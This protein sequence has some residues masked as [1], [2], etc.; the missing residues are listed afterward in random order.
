MSPTAKI[1]AAEAS[2][3]AALAALMCEL[4]YATSTSDM[5]MRLERIGRDPQYRTFVA[6]EEGKVCGMI[7]SFALH[8]Y[9][10]NDL[11]GRIMAL[12]VEKNSRR[13]G[14]GRRL[15]SAAEYDFAQRNIVRVAVNTRFERKEAHEFY[16][17]LGYIRNGFRFVKNLAV[18][19]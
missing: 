17:S 8:S 16:E 7:G 1:R 19:D 5:Q 10:N 6:V 12:V 4:G 2:D 3:A 18:A 13:T 14:I 15:I 9:E 11:G